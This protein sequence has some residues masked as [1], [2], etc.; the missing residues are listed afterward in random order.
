MVIFYLFL[1]E[2][3]FIFIEIDEFMVNDDFKSF[4][5]KLRQP[6][7]EEI[8]MDKKVETTMTNLE[9]EAILRNKDCLKKILEDQ[10]YPTKIII[11]G[12]IGKLLFVAMFLT[13]TFQF[14]LANQQAYNLELSLNECYQTQLQMSNFLLIANSIQELII[15]NRNQP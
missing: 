8:P 3:L 13:S 6:V 7:F 15:L 2:N 4:D 14:I 11:L 9:F 1:I 5:P 10:P 12:L